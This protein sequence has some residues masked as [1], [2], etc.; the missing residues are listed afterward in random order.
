VID[1]QT[2]LPTLFAAAQRGA[3]LRVV[4]VIARLNVG[5]PARQVVVL[6]DQLRA[7]GCDTLLV[8]G[9]PGQAEGTLD[10]LARVRGVPTRQIATLG[11]RLSAVDDVV[12]AWRLFAI[13]RSARPDV[14]HTH[15]AKA[16]ALGRTAGGLYNLTRR[17][18]RRCAIVHTFHGH[19]FSGYFGK[20]GSRIAQAIE[21]GLARLTDRI[22]TLSTQQRDEIAVRFR[23]AP[24]AKVAVVGAGHDL[25]ALLTMDAGA[26]S[27][28]AALGWTDAHVIVG[29]VGRLVAIKDLATLFRAFADVAAARPEVRLLVAGDGD[30]RAPLERLAAEL[31]IT[32]STRFIGWFTDLPRLYATIDIVALTSRNEGMPASLIE[33]MAAGRAIV[34]TAVGGVPELIANG[35]SGLIVPPGDVARTARAIRDLVDHP[36]RRAALGQRAR[37]AA[38]DRFAPARFARET[39]EVYDAAIR[40]RRGRSSHAPAHSAPEL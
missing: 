11:R 9:A 1:P 38:A 14:L 3:R 10:D 21:R 28:R 17:R 32:E 19:V 4:R 18:S 13:L 33:G 36:D 6:D 22:I 40:A 12:T 24:A 20:A 31:G 16:G 25:S 15:T 23:I 39:L 2:P 34:A 5:G 35:E 29:Y 27:Q 7:L 8:Y 37:A 26:A 30:Q